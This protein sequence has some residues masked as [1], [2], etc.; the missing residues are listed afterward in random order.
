[1]NGYLAA[2]LAGLCIGI[3]L[4]MARALADKLTNGEKR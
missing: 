1:M 2:F 4:E 3:A